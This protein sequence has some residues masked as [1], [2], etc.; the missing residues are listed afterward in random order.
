MQGWG[1]MRVHVIVNYI[2][3]LGEVA[4]DPWKVWVLYYVSHNFWKVWRATIDR[5]GCSLQILHS[6][7]QD[8][9]KM[10]P[11][12]SNLTVVKIFLEA[13]A[14][15]VIA[16]P[17]T[18][19]HWW[20]ALVAHSHLHNG[21]EWSEQANRST[22]LFGRHDIFDRPII[23]DAQCMMSISAL[24]GKCRT[25]LMHCNKSVAFPCQALLMDQIRSGFL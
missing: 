13:S 16:A 3:T 24:S 9:S 6:R 19:Y 25:S 14:L 8:G 18:R 5:A 4:R 20:L 1:I 23:L 17:S 21:L 2:L 12:A 10:L 22:D 15:G 7:H 11:V